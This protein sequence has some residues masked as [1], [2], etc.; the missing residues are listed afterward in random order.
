V[1]IVPPVI[2]TLMDSLRV[3]TDSGQDTT[4][5]GNN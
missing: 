2:D 3:Q 4:R 1:P 5:T